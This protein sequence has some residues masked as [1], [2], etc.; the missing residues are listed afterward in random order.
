MLALAFVAFDVLV[1]RCVGRS[2][3]WKTWVE[4]DVQGES[5]RVEG[6]LASQISVESYTSP[7][8]LN[9]VMLAPAREDHCQQGCG[10]LLSPQVFF[11]SDQ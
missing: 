9:E 3:N 8:S 6:G 10:C 2:G 11:M 7:L 5:E 4:D 1:R